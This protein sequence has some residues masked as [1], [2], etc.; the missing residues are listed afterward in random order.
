MLAIRTKLLFER[1][2]RADCIGFCVVLFLA[3]K[4]AGGV[5]PEN[6][7]LLCSPGERLRHLARQYEREI[8]KGERG[9]TLRLNTSELRYQKYILNMKQGVML[10]WEYPDVAVRN[11]WQGILYIDFTINKD[12]TLGDVLVRKSSGSPVLDDA[13]VTALRLAAPFPPFPDNFL[14]EKINIKARF[15]YILRSIPI[16]SGS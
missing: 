12:G 7:K 5:E 4:C 8:P 6:L 15:E 9:K 2:T 3:G 10:R 1:L 13:A 11:G 14:V 16:G